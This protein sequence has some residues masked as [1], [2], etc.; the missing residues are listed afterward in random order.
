[1]D[2]SFEAALKTGEI[3]TVAPY[4]GE[5]IRSSS[6]LG[7][8]SKTDDFV[9]M[10]IH[11]VDST[12]LSHSDSIMPLLFAC[13]WTLMH[14]KRVTLKNGEACISRINEA[15]QQLDLP[16][17]KAALAETRGCLALAKD[18]PEQASEHFHE[19][20][21]IWEQIERP[22]DQLRAFA[23]LGEALVRTDDKERAAQVFDQAM[24][25]VAMLADQLDDQTLRES[26]LSSQLV[27]Q[28]KTSQSQLENTD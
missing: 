8:E 2:R 11:H 19:A 25:I 6:A 5:L 22:Y 14:R 3:Q 10:L 13:Y 26:F 17:T 16:M 4:I 21:K 1:L 9:E 27:Q 20:V 23:G 24:G 15:Y 18:H 28:I 7:L 12:P